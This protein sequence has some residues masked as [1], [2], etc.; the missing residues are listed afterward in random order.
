MQ[1]PVV[2]TVNIFFDL[3]IEFYIRACSAALQ[4]S[5]SQNN[6]FVPDGFRIAVPSDF[7]FASAYVIA[8]YEIALDH[9]DNNCIITTMHP[10]QARPHLHHTVLVAITLQLSLLLPTLL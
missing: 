6:M 5:D 2:Y 1:N 7:E 9:V 10:S 4:I 3:F 8:P